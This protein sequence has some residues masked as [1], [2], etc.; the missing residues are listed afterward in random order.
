[1]DMNVL[2]K[3]SEIWPL[4]WVEYLTTQDTF[5]DIYYEKYQIISRLLYLI[6]FILVTSFQ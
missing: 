6:Y 2:L 1:M 3:D 5:V 4:S